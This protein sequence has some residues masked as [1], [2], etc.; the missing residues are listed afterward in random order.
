MAWMTVG[1]VADSPLEVAPGVEAPILAG[2]SSIRI[3]WSEEIEEDID[4]RRDET[5][6][7][8]EAKD[9]MLLGTE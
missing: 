2:L 4:T 9:G 3:A 5:E 1:S 6:R 7:R 8:L